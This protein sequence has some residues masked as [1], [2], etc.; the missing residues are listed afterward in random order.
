V[1]QQILLG[2]PYLPV[3]CSPY[4]KGV[5]ERGSNHSSFRRSRVVQLQL[6]E[7]ALADGLRSAGASYVQFAD[8][9]KHF[10]A[11]EK[12]WVKRFKLLWQA[13]RDGFGVAESHHGCD[14]HANTLTLILDTDG[15]IFSGFTAV[16]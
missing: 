1:L 7:I 2:L 12:F 8:C 14:G 4:P 6:H 5:F 3:I 15:N 13:S 9:T 10:T 16:E 11:F